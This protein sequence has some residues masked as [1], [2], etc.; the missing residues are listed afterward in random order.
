MSPRSKL[1]KARREKKKADKADK[2]NSSRRGKQLTAQS[3]SGLRHLRPSEQETKHVMP[4]PNRKPPAPPKTTPAPTASTVSNPVQVRTHKSRFNRT[5]SA[6]PKSEDLDEDMQKVEISIARSISVTKRPKKLLVPI[7]ARTGSTRAEKRLVE[8]GAGIP[9]L[10][11]V[12]KG[13]RHEAR[14]VLIESM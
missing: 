5:S 7:I 11:S 14:N 9:T 2:Y 3:T 1:Q 4:P 10:V 13:H 6:A 8:K 12:Q